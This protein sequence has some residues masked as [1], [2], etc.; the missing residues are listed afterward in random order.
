MAKGNKSKSAKTTNQK[1]HKEN[2]SKDLRKKRIQKQKENEKQYA[3]N[4][5][6]TKVVQRS[7][8]DVSAAP[9]MKGERIKKGYASTYPVVENTSSGQGFFD[10]RQM[11]NEYL[12]RSEK[13]LSFDHFMRNIS[14]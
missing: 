7:N 13:G 4:G 5:G 14:T 12:A 2:L 8:R 10:Q 6:G 11:L 3:Y 1:K 9:A